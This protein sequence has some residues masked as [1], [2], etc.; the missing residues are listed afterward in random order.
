MFVSLYDEDVNNYPKNKMFQ[1]L[2]H[3]FLENDWMLGE[4]TMTKMIYYNPRNITDEF[5][6]HLENKVIYATIPI[7]PGNY[8]YT[9]SFTSFFL[10]TEYISFH[11]KN[12]ENKFKIN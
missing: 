9:T 8:E 1:E 11:L 2:H 12:Y 4:N 7:T 10:A 3:E 5:K 6:I